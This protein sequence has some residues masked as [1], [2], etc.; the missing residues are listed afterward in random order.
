MISP[1]YECFK[2]ETPLNK[3]TSGTINL[4][5][6]KSQNIPN[7][8]AKRGLIYSF[9]KS[10]YIKR[11]LLNKPNAAKLMNEC[12]YH[13]LSCLKDDDAFWER[14]RITGLEK[15]FVR[16]SNDRIDD[17]LSTERG[18]KIGTVNLRGE[19]RGKLTM[20]SAPSVMY[21]MVNTCEFFLLLYSHM[22][23]LNSCIMFKGPFIS[24]LHTGCGEKMT[25]S[26]ISRQ[27]LKKFLSWSQCQF[28]W[29]NFSLNVI[30]TCSDRINISY[31]C[32]YWDGKVQ[33][34]SLGHLK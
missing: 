30:F 34:M 24:S 9:F 12:P 14:T 10:G 20:F 11:V 4:A 23:G 32:C 26:I 8:F 27:L 28:L 5:R 18:E 7:F 17:N 19:K 6:L 1:S 22:D 31:C 33:N 16:Q 3:A 15:T 2:R 13:K 21:V 29:G 25:L